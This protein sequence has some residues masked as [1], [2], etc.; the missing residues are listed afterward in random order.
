MDSGWRM[1]MVL[2]TGRQREEMEW[3]R[4]GLV[5]MGRDIHRGIQGSLQDGREVV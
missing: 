5:V 1:V 4:E 2:S 3:I